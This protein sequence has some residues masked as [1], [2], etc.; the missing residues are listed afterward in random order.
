MSAP[1]LL[2]P[3]QVQQMM[4]AAA[5][6]GPW[7]MPLLE[8]L[9]AGDLSIQFLA[10]NQPAPIEGMEQVAGPLLAYVGDDD[11]RSCGPDGWQCALDVA[12]WARAGLIHAAAGRPEHYAAAAA[13]T[14]AERRFVLVET[15]SRHALTWGALLAGKPVLHILPRGGAHPI[16]T[17]ETRH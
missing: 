13:G 1:H 17:R 16:A 5:Q 12:R 9:Q 14:I 10:R 3:A 7:T 15:S 4:Q 2:S 11:E 6:V 8:A